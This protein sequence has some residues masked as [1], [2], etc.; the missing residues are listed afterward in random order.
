[1]AGPL[2]L[3]WLLIYIIGQLTKRVVALR[4]S[5]NPAR[6]S[7]LQLEEVVNASSS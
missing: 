7:T 5:L 2:C 6:V 4:D 3:V 1:M